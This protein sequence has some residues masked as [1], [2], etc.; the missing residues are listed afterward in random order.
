MMLVEDGAEFSAE[1]IVL[2]LAGMSIDRLSAVLPE[3]IW[4]F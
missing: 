1:G 2:I 4:V 3:K